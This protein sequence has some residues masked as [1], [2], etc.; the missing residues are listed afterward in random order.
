M[1][2]L[3]SSLTCCLLAVGATAATAGDG[4]VRA[5]TSAPI[6]PDGDV[7]SRPVDL[8]IHF[9]TS[10]DPAVPGRTLLQG[11]SIRV[12]LPDDF[13]IADD[14][15]LSLLG[16][17][18]CKPPSVACNTMI[19]LQGWP[20]RPIRPPTAKYQLNVEG[21]HT[22][23]LTA[24]E[25]LVPAPPDEP[26]IKQVHINLPDAG[27]PESGSYEIEIVAETGPDGTAETATPTIEIRPAT[28]PMIAIT[29]LLFEPPGLNSNYQHADTGKE[30]PRAFDF[31][32]WDAAGA[33]LVGAEIV[34]GE[35]VKDGAPIG[36]VT[37]NAPAGATGQGLRTEAPSTAIGDPVK[38]KPAGHL[39][40]FFQAGSE[41]G[42]Y[43]VDVGL[44][45]GNAAQMIVRVQ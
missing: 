4:M 32:V 10:P 27:N 15:Q 30:P 5:I 18:G 9:D 16:T 33:P 41:P 23:V 28:T 14:L 1:R 7:A 34:D 29:N 13:I 26:G 3:M 35:I 22:L 2:M 6:V 37:I 42:D 17:E 19:L 20:Q 45:G 8:V 31:L 38:S 39:R 11:K 44:D 25:D 36:K 12:T 24:I 21:T 40:A 43:V